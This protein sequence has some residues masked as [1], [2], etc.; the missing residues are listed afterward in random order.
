MTPQQKAD[1][2]AAAAALEAKA[3]AARQAA[4]DLDALAA[5]TLKA[6][7]SEVPP[8]WLTGDALKAANLTEALARTAALTVRNATS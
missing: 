6:R 4:Q 3:K 1:L 5:T 2:Q 7:G 8:W